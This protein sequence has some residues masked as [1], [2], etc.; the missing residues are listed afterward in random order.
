V[1]SSSRHS[2]NANAFG[3]LHLANRDSH[4][5]L[6]L[7]AQ[8]GYRKLVIEELDRMLADAK[9]GRPIRRSIS[10]TE[11]SDH[12]KDYDRVIAMLEMSVDDTVIEFCEFF[13]ILRFVAPR[14]PSA[15]L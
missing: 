12:T 11:P 6:F 2:T 10:L 9:A 7:K 4:R 13:R 5:H 3:I 14:S 1:L 15:T 8:E